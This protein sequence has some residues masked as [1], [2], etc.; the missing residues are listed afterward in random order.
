LVNGKL[1]PPVQTVDV[2]AEVTRVLL[3]VDAMVNSSLTDIDGTHEASPSLILSALEAIAK[4]RGHLVRLEGDVKANVE[5]KVTNDNFLELAAKEMQ[6]RSR[7]PYQLTVWQTWITHVWD[8]L[9]QRRRRANRNYHG[10]RQR[11][12]EEVGKMIGEMR[13]VIDRQ[14]KELKDQ[15]AQTAH[16]QQ[17]LVTQMTTAHQAKSLPQYQSSP[18]NM[19]TQQVARTH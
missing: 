16:L 11:M 9:Q 10:K 2:E 19:Y 17:L 13:E 4:Y 15:H 8:T 5:F 6:R 1:A 14:G 3:A 7:D 18:M 12:M